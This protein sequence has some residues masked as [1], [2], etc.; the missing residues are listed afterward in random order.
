MTGQKELLQNLSELV[1]GAFGTFQHQVPNE[2][3]GN[4]IVLYSLY[5]RYFTNRAKQMKVGN[6]ILSNKCYCERI[7]VTLGNRK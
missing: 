7:L 4:V 6:Q 3:F 2:Y 5:F 1:M